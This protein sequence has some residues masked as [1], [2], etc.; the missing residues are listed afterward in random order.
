VQVIADTGED[1]LA[2]ADE[3]VEDAELDPGAQLK[4]MRDRMKQ[5]Q[6][7]AAKPTIPA[8]LLNNANSYEDK[9]AL[10]RMIVSQEHD[11]VAATIR[12]MVQAN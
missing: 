4:Q 10:V 2:V 9:L 3:A 8:E 7:L 6:K 1:A 11:R 12:R 5:E